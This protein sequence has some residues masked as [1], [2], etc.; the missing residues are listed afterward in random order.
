MGHLPA[1]VTDKRG[2]VH[3]LRYVRILVT[4]NPIL[5]TYRSGASG[6]LLICTSA[7]FSQVKKQHEKTCEASDTVR[8][9]KSVTRQSQAHHHPSALTRDALGCHCRDRCSKFALRRNI[10]FCQFIVL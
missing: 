2:A 3:T 8:E 5:Q 10:A 7:V 1:T 4:A 9:E 6:G